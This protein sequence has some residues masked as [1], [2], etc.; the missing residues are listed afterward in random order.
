MKLCVVGC[1][2]IGGHLAVKMALAGADVSALARGETLK[3]IRHQGLTLE[4]AAGTWTVP[5]RAEQD[6]SVLGPQEVVIVAVK[7]TAL[8][9]IA[10]SLPPLIGPQTC[11]VFM[12][13]GL[14]WW[15]LSRLATDTAWLSPPLR[16]T[17][18][19]LSTVVAADR[20]IGGIANSPNDVP[21]PGVV[22]N[23]NPKGAFIF[24]EIDNRRTL[25]V[26]SLAAMLNGNDGV[27]IAT[28][29]IADEVWKKLYTNVVSGPL[30]SLT[31]AATAEVFGDA[32]LA[33]LVERMGGELIA[34][35]EACGSQNRPADYLFSKGTGAHKTSMLQDF[36]AGRRPEIDSLL[37]ALVDVAKLQGVPVPALDLIARILRKRAKTLGLYP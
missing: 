26:E 34:V 22:R 11:V 23:S 3:A 6:A 24:G 25:R 36:E 14:P 21:R 16:A 2:A 19:A 9:D 32:D 15:L 13:N 30:G 27:G 20:I 17:V 28:T 7:T 18:Q 35:A 5:V 12:V 29:A 33:P 10:S 31:G 1:G 4:S 37:G 8:T